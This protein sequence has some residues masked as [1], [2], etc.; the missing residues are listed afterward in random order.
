MPGLNEEGYERTLCTLSEQLRQSQS[1]ISDLKGKYTELHEMIRGH[2]KHK[3]DIESGAA[4]PP[5]LFEQDFY[6]FNIIYYDRKYYAIDQGVGAIDFARDDLSAFV[7]EFKCFI[8]RSST[9]VKGLV[10]RYTTLKEKVAQR[11]SIIVALKGALADRDVTMSQGIEQLR[12]DLSEKD[13]IIEQQQKAISERDATIDS[14]RAIVSERDQLIENL[15][16]DAT[17]KYLA[18]V[19][20]QKTLAQ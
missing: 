19:Q 6:G 15:Q 5:Y 18:I 4:E 7:G 11:D 2:T 9:E 8:S 12:K 14:L 17:E 3:A 1:D 20:L 16:K 13:L 10:E